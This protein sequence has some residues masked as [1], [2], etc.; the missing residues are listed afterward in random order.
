MVYEVKYDFYYSRGQE[1]ELKE[2][3]EYVE[4][5]FKGKLYTQMINAGVK[6]SDMERYRDL[7]KIGR[8]VRGDITYK[9]NGKEFFNTLDT[10]VDLQNKISSYKETDKENKNTKILIKPF[11]KVFKFAID[12]D[13]VEEY[14]SVNEAAAK[15]KVSAS[16]ISNCIKSRQKSAAGFT[17]KFE[18]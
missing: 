2:D 17:W 12:G 7:V 1:E 4:S 18:R 9:K 3:D 5:F 13:F 6:T 8:G 16:S 15:N 14:I 11:K 10:R